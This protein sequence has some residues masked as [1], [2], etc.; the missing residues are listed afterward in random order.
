M[1][2][3]RSWACPVST[4]RAPGA[5]RTKGTLPRRFRHRAHLSTWPVRP[6]SRQESGNCRRPG[7]APV[8]AFNLIVLDVAT[9][10]VSTVRLSGHR[11]GDEGLHYSS[12]KS[13]A[14]STAPDREETPSLR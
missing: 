7:L 3:F 4:Y 1:S 2:A 11:P 9:V 12:C 13:L 14:R 8:L 5:N 6:Y 10:V